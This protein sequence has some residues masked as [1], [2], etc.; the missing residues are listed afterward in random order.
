VVRVPD[1]R[2]RG[3]G[4]DSWRQQIFWEIVALE[5][6]PLCLLRTTEE[7]HKWKSNCSESKKT[8]LSIYLWLYSPYLGLGSSFSFLIFYTVTKTSW[9]GP[10]PVATCVQ[11]STNTE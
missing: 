11:E 3:L 4:F 7:L 9:T 5:W 6:D 1:Y 10:Q 2:F 8:H